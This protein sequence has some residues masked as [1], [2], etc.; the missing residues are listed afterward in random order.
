MQYDARQGKNMDILN[1]F[2]LGKV[3]KFRWQELSWLS[4]RK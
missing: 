4:D 3:V 2:Q 1:V